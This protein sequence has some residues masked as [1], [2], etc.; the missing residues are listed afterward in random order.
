MTD[1]QM[2]NS[3]AHESITIIKDLISE[4]DLVCGVYGV[5]IEV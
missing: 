5:S 3:L 1:L 2:T 4:N